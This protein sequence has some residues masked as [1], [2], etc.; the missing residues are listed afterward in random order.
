MRRALAGG[1]GFEAD[2][3][4]RLARVMTPPRTVTLPTVL[5]AVEPRKLP[6]LPSPV[7]ELLAEPA[8]AHSSAGATARPER[9][10][11]HRTRTPEV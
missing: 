10:S 11:G 2:P 6:E 5:M 8:P 4:E 9:A 7:P 3:R 1:F